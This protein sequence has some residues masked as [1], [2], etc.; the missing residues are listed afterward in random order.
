MERAVCSGSFDPVTNGHLDIIKRAARIFD[1]I[2]VCVF[3][4]QSKAGMFTPKERIALLAEA[5]TD[6]KNLSIDSFDGLLVDYLKINKVSVVV[7][8]LRGSA[9]LAYEMQNALLNKH[10][11]PSCE[12]VFLP[13]S[14]QWTAVSSS[15]VRTI[16]AFGGD[17]S[18]L[19]PDSVAQAVVNKL[20]QK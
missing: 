8:G 12:T 18:E 9:D 2:I 20:Q 6:I 1:E 10:L 14:P 19:V 17:I 7:R 4:N 3:V 5:T 11:F 13:A 15:A 16:A